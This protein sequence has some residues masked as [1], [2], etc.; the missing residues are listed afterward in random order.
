MRSIIHKSLHGSS[1]PT[2][3]SARGSPTCSFCS[4]NSL[5]SG[6][7]V[8]EGVTHSKTKN[9]SAR[10]AP[11][12]PTHISGRSRLEST[13]GLLSSFCSQKK[14]ENG[15]YP[16]RYMFWSWN[17]GFIFSVLSLFRVSV[18]ACDWLVLLFLGGHF[19]RRGEGILYF[20]KIDDYGFSE[21]SGKVLWKGGG[22]R[23]EGWCRWGVDSC[24]N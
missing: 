24:L 14:S 1:G 4:Q 11:Q 15:Y 22:K 23:R 2:A 9:N 3:G 8:G 13:V 18:V 20:L 16:L 21:G 17:L 6:G 19:F 5:K 12:A 7:G 10:E